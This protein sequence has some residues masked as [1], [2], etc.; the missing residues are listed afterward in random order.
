MRPNLK[1]GLPLSTVS[2][3]SHCVDRKLDVLVRQ[4]KKLDVAVTGIQ[5]TK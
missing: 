5:E 1:S 3:D 2:S 4:L